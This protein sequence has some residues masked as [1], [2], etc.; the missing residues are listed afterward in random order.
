M[1]LSYKDYSVRIV[2][3]PN[4]TILRFVDTKT[5]RIWEAT[6]TERNFIE[7]QILGGVDFVVSV[8]KDALTTE[9]YPI[10]DFK[11]TPK[12]LSFTIEYIPDEHCKMLPIS[13]AFTAVKRES[14]NLDLET[15]TTQMNEMK[16]VFQKMH[17]TSL[18]KLSSKIELLEKELALEKE[19][20]QGFI[21]LPGCTQAIDQT[22]TSLNIG[23]RGA[24]NPINGTAYTTIGNG[25]YIHDN[26]K[27][28]KNLTYL[29]KCTTLSLF[30]TMTLVDYSPI[31][32]MTQL[33]NLSIVYNNNNTA[34]VNT[35]EWA[36]K[37]VN[38]ETV[39]LYGCLGL[40]D[41]GPLAKLPK[42]KSLDIR[43]TGVKNTSMF[44]SSVSITR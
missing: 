19:K 24:A 28:I 7:Y 12:N 27:S 2:Y 20:T 40:T 34:T 37:L 4:D 3:N 17:D 14:A 9:V 31:G 42:L 43:T 33:K 22:L 16:Q 44:S 13:L 23:Q 30:N 21:I 38:L 26:L 5:M 18:N 1:D 6:L 41:I 35:L 15:L 11:A 36:T 29:N 8:L 10:I 25:L 32:E 39:C